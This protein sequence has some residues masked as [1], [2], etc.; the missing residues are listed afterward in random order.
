MRLDHIA[1][2]VKDRHKTVEFFIQAFGY[3]VQTEF[4]LKFDDGTTARC[5]ALEPPEKPNQALPWT[6]LAK[7]D[8]VEY[9][10]APEIF[11]S[12]GDPGSI[13]GQWVA[14]RGGIGGIHHLAYQVESVQ[15]KMDEW[16]AKGFA[17]FTTEQP[18]TC[19][20][21]TQVFTKPSQLTGVI[22]EFI[23]RGVHGF[24]ADNVKDLMLSTKDADIVAVPTS[25]GTVTV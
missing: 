10:L 19:P 4:D 15:A 14:A 22:Y 21:L 8:G 5:F 11:V 12:D 13:V 23:E 25:R 16:R 1:Y 17:E 2:R 24:C 7:P 6:H 20:D 18:L 9:H 3:R